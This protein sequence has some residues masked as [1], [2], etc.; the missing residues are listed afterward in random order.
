MR[1]VA[2]ARVSTGNQRDNLS[3]GVQFKSI[4]DYAQGQGWEKVGEFFDNE[5]R[6][7]F[8]EREGLQEALKMVRQ[9][10]ADL[11]IFYDVSR[12]GVDVAINPFLDALYQ[13]GGKLGIATERRIFQTKAE[14][15]EQTHWTKAVSTFEYLTIKRRTSAGKRRAIELGGFVWYQPFGYKLETVKVDGEK[16][17]KLAVDEVEAALIIEIYES[18]IAGESRLDLCNRLNKSGYKRNFNYNLIKRIEL[19]ADKYV[20]GTEYRSVNIDGEEVGNTYT[21]PRIISDDLYNRLKKWQVSA[22]R[23]YNKPDGKVTPFKGLA[24]CI[25]CEENAQIGGRRHGSVGITC[26]TYKRYYYAK[27]Q[28]LPLPEHYCPHQISHPKIRKAVIAYLED[29]Y[30]RDLKDADISEFYPHRLYQPVIDQL[31]KEKEELEKK[32]FELPSDQLLHVIE[33][34]NERLAGLKKNIQEQEEK[35]HS[36]LEFKKTVSY[37][38]S[39]VNPEKKQEAI[40]AMNANDWETANGLLYEL[41]IVIGIGFDKMPV[42]VDPHLNYYRL[43]KPPTDGG[44]G[45]FTG[46]LD[47]LSIPQDSWQIGDRLEFKRWTAT[48]LTA[49]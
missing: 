31:K 38:L 32:L 9:D 35:L 11:I 27:Q 23:G 3:K 2:L 22:S 14:A 16:V 48:F 25:H 49:S 10:K 47:R 26:P 46:T 29:G 19:Q 5:S 6:T 45:G 34:F 12:V 37:L 42:E 4:D 36:A 43:M 20:G 13:A 44:E 21:F 40:D 24:Y 30:E 33:A 7:T 18:L 8:L 39:N 1:Y 17:K 41:G 28:G 15:L